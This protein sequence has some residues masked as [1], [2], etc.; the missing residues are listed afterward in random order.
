MKAM[1]IIVAVCAA[2]LVYRFSE[3][4]KARHAVKMDDSI[5]AKYRNLDD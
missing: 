1:L 5:P 4:L 3:M 2:V